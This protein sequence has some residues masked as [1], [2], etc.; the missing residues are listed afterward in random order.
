MRNAC[1]VTDPGES[2]SELK[3]IETVCHAHLSVIFYIVLSG[4]K[5]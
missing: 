2:K 5:L 3:V 4:I 1:S